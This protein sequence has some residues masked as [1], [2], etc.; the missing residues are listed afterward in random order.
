MI[1]SE[2]PIPMMPKA[3]RAVRI[4]LPPQSG[5][6]FLRRD[7]PLFLH[8]ES[9]QRQD[10]CEG[11]GGDEGGGDELNDAISTD[12]EQQ[13]RHRRQEGC[14]EVGIVRLTTFGELIAQGGDFLPQF[15]GAGGL[16]AV[17]FDQPEL[18]A[19]LREPVLEAVVF[20]ARGG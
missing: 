16:P 19:I 13:R 17:G 14:P 2:A 20:A 10:R 18:D 11:E 9:H 8:L 6:Q 5:A 7:G 3:P 1:S 12:I 4:G 15:H